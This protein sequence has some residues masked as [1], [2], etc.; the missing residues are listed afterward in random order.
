MYMY[1]IQ[2]AFVLYGVLL[3]F[4][5]VCIWTWSSHL[6]SVASFRQNFRHESNVSF[7]RNRFH[8]LA[9]T[10][11]KIC[12]ECSIIRTA[13]A[14]VS[15]SSYI[16]PYDAYATFAKVISAFA[17]A[18]KLTKANFLSKAAFAL[19]ERHKAFNSVRNIFKSFTF[20]VKALCERGITVPVHPK[21]RWTASEWDCRNLRV[22]GNKERGGVPVIERWK[23][24][25]E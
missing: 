11:H 17:Q 19:C 4:F 14:C 8:R 13:D 16:N 12:F 22:W 2:T 6:R 9:F 20:V 5:V 25:W 15:L 1:G 24:G 10:Q 18:R 21:M 23:I 3:F 7:E